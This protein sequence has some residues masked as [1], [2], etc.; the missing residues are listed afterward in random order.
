MNDNSIIEL[1]F[2]R[3]ENA[4]KETQNK[5]SNYCFSISYNILK[6]KMKLKNV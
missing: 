3:N 4:I 5:Y 6:N 1:F 2:N